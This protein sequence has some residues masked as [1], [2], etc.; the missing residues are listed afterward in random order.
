MVSIHQSISQMCAKLGQDRLI[1]QG[2]GGNIS[3]KEDEVLWIKGSGTWLANADKEDIFVPVDLKHLQIALS[4]ANFAVEPKMIKD[5]AA[6]KLS[7]SI[8][9]ILHA[10][11]PQKIVAHLHAINPLSHLVTKDCAALISQICKQKNIDGVFVEYHKPG[12]HLAKAVYIALQ[13][14]SSTNVIFL[15]NHGIVIG[16]ET[17]EE[18]YSLLNKID[19]AFAPKQ[20]VIKSSLAPENISKSPIDGYTPCN[21]IDIQALVFDPSLFQRLH[22]GWVLFPDHAVFLGATANIYTTWNELQSQAQN[23]H[24]ELIFIKNTGVFVKSE[25]NPA[26]IAQLVC[27]FDVISRV[28]PGGQLDP[29]SNEAVNDLL[30]WDAEKL[31]QKMII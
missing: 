26:K 4:N 5:Q 10:L 30:N 23:K 24:P 3:W 17:I 1:V 7:P 8:E 25:F 6:Q 11:M 19:K 22:Q 27:Y 16:A 18:I 20:N 28:T 2:A 9:T 21:N 13:N 14:T 31:R 29:L 12:L 15:K